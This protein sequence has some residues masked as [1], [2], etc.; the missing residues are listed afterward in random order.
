MIEIVGSYKLTDQGLEGFTGELEVPG[1][2]DLE[3]SGLPRSGQ[4]YPFVQGILSSS[5][6]P[7]IV[8]LVAENDAHY[9]WDVF[10]AS[11][12]SDFAR[13][14]SL[15]SLSIQTGVMG[16]YEPNVAVFSGAQYGLSSV[17][18][19]LDELRRCGQDEGISINAKSLSDVRLFISN[20]AFLGELNIF[21]LDNGNFRVIWDVG[22]EEEYGIEFRGDRTIRQTT[23]RVEPTSRRVEITSEI[24]D[25]ASLTR[26]ISRVATAR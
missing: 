10:P 26:P 23:I 24:T 2:T 8:K 9:E 17:E 7:V 12:V 5:G 18:S 4:Y 13:T 19:R 25:F 14:A 11:R 15:G 1:L 22:P 20:Q 16:R 6:Y 21:L 3:L